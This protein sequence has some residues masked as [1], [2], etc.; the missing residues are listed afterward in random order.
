YVRS[1]HVEDLALACALR[2]GSASAWEEFVR[3]YRPALYSAA[4]AIVGSAGE[5]RARELADSLWAELYGMEGAGGSR[6]QP[7]LGY[8]HGRSKFSTWLRAILSQRH[9]DALR[10]SNRTESLEEGTDPSTEPSL[11]SNAIR[12]GGSTDSVGDPDRNRLLPRLRQ[13]VTAA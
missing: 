4:R 6:G 13:A 11:R 9:V 2:N 3:N 8:F 7:L 12:N 10:T 5:A 1:L